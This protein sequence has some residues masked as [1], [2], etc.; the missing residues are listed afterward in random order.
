MVN[1]SSVIAPFFRT[2]ELVNARKKIH[3]EQLGRQNV[4]RDP[5][6]RT[7]PCL[8]SSIVAGVAVHS[9]V[10][11]YLYTTALCIA[12]HRTA[13][14]LDFTLLSLSLSLSLCFF[15][16]CF[17]AN[18]SSQRQVKSIQV[19]SP[20]T[21]FSLSLSLFH[22]FLPSF[23]PSFLA[24]R[25]QHTHS[26][27]HT[28]TSLFPSFLP[29]FLF[30]PSFISFPL[31]PTRPIDDIIHTHLPH[32]CLRTLCTCI[33]AFPP[34]PPAAALPF[35]PHKQQQQQQQQQQQRMDGWMDLFHSAAAA[36][37]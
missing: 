16:F 36:L 3:I 19:K 17:E 8:L 21:L 5:R 1:E 13:W 11:L 33:F 24:Q 31:F 37:R 34:P 20:K 28:V 7:D 10:A 22:S 9:Y 4:V 30:L 12:S 25:T 27:T 15:F 32:A 26:L 6:D 23:I 35:L 29:S 2:F 14:L 18:K